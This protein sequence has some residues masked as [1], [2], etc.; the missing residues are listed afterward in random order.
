M[1]RGPEEAFS[2]EDIQIANRHM[3]RC[4]TSLITREMQIKIT[5]RYHLTPVIMVITKTS[6]NNNVVE[7]RQDLCTVGGN[8]NWCSHYGKQYGG[9]SKSKTRTTI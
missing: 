2:K 1:G 7:K 9:S 5:I 4:S 6:T 3:N 8:V